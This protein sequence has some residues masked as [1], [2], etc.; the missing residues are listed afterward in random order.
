VSFGACIRAHLCRT[1]LDARLVQTVL[2]RATVHHPL[3]RPCAGRARDCRRKVA[4]C[5]APPLRPRLIWQ[6]CVSEL[7]HLGDRPSRDLSASKKGARRHC[8]SSKDRGLSGVAQKSALRRLCSCRCGAAGA[9][10]H[11]RGA[12][13]GPVSPT[14]HRVDRRGSGAHLGLK[15]ERERIGTKSQLGRSCDPPILKDRQWRRGERQRSPLGGRDGAAGP[16]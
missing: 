3:G 4:G 14:R 13:D 5:S 6:I 2:P 7:S 1:T 11:S 15:S 16:R 8:E 9:Q 12:A 10:V